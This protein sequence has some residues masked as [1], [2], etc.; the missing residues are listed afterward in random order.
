MKRIA[1]R[2]LLMQTANWTNLKMLS[3]KNN[4]FTKECTMF[5]AV[6]LTLWRMQTNS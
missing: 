2:N 3:E 1:Q 5:G 6:Y 4:M